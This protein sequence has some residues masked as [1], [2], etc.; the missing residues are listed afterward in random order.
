VR[1]HL[2]IVL[3]ALGAVVLA[4]AP[5]ACGV[6]SHGATSD[7]RSTP[8]VEAPAEPDGIFGVGLMNWMVMTRRD[9]VPAGVVTFQ[10]THMTE[11]MDDGTINGGKTHELEVLRKLPDGT[12]EVAG[13]TGEIPLGEQR[14]LTLT[15]TA[16]AYELRCSLTEDVG[17][18]QVSHYAL[19]MH[20][21]L[22]VK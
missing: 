21:V 5:F 8:I 22:V 2:R 6:F 19:G 15:L 11:T 9:M 1:Q 7:A 13:N 17:G 16:G 20:T 4:T 3:L 18:K 10:A 14:T 12:Y